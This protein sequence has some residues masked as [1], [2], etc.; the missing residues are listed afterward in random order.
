M[1]QVSVLFNRFVCYCSQSRGNYT[2]VFSFT[3]TQ[4][5]IS[6]VNTVRFLFV[7]VCGGQVSAGWS[8]VTVKNRCGHACCFRISCRS[9]STYCMSFQFQPISAVARQLRRS[10]SSIFRILWLF[11]AGTSRRGAV[12]T[13]GGNWSPWWWRWCE[14]NWWPTLFFFPQWSFLQLSRKLRCSSWSSFTKFRVCLW[15]SFFHHVQTVNIL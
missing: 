13:Y 3:I 10:S 2:I 11:V 1:I 9:L 5:T 14:Y 7:S 12:K 8:G 4:L 6:H 15:E